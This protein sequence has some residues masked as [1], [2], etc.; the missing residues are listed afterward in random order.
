M[1]RIVSELRYAAR[2]VFENPRFTL[3]AVAALAL[4]IGANAAT[5]SVVSAVLLQPLPYADA[6][7]LVRARSDCADRMLPARPARGARRSDCRAQTGV[8]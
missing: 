8:G 6:S 5:F 1:D 3:V 7:R 2:A 4:G